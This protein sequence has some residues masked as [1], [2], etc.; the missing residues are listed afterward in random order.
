M[1]KARVSCDSSPIPNRH[2]HQNQTTF[3]TLVEVK[4][5]SSTGW[6]PLA[7]FLSGASGHVHNSH[8]VQSLNWSWLLLYTVQ[9]LT[10]SAEISSTLRSEPHRSPTITDWI[11]S[12]WGQNRKR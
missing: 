8:V 10:S 12:G 6:I 3:T 7:V 9:Y 2:Q 11:E 4:W 1:E 5:Q